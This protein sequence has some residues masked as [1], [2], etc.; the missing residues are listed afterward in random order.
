[1]PLPHVPLPQ[2]ARSG[3]SSENNRS[4]N[5]RA[6]KFSKLPGVLNLPFPVRS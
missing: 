3:F 6:L 1:M 4:E 5:N 2:P